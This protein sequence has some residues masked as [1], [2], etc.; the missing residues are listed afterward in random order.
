MEL[1]KKILS[2]DYDDDD[3]NYQAFTEFLDENTQRTKNKIANDFEK[4]GQDLLAEIEIKKL[5]KEIK[6]QKLIL[7]I[8][9]HSK[10]VFS[11]HVLKSY[12]L[13]DVQEIYNELKQTRSTFT[14]FFHFIF[15]IE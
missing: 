7:Y 5:K 11:E 15:N 4:I 14:K 13:E 2:I 9:K 12:T 6:K 3:K 8:L 1:N 10:D